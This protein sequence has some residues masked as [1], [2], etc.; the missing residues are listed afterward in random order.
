MSV[1]SDGL[2][3]DGAAALAARLAG[4][5]LPARAVMEAHLNRI[6]A[7][8]P[9]LCAFI[10]VAADEA[11]A[12]AAEL[13]ATL[14]RTGRSAGPL[15]GLPVV[16]KDLTDTAGIRTTYGSALHADH[17]PSTSDIAVARIEAAG[18]IVIGKTNTPEFGF[19]AICR[20]RLAGPTRNPF[21]ARLTSGGSSGGSAVAV[22]AGMAPLAHG[23]DFGGSVRV[24]A[25]F[26]GVASIRP[27]PGLIPSPGR[28]L[29]WD[30][31]A[32][33][34]V[35][36]RDTTDCALL[37]SAMAGS[38]LR[39]P[40]SLFGDRDDGSETRLGATADFGV[41]TVSHAVRE[42]FAAAVEQLERAAGPVARR[43]PDCGDAMATFRTLRAA[44]IRHAYGPL[45][46]SHGD[47][48]TDTVRWNIE[49]GSGITADAYLAAQTARTALYRRFVALFEEID[50]L[51]AP[52]C[53]VLPWPNE[54]GEVTVIDGRPVETILDYLGVTAIVTLIGFPVLTLP[55]GGDGLP[56][57][58]QLIARPGEERR[59]I[60]LG[61]M[62]EREAGFVHRWPPALA[63]R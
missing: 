25:S 38:D 30:T 61:R 63:T 19:G 41:A 11:L 33:H 7:A 28:A 62:L 46:D 15:H 3:Q 6:A 12:R 24:P 18:G 22:A 8:D 4:G 31:L 13:D 43:H 57:G 60:R 21:D 48:L 56:F 52:A 34:G 29:G 40:T 27:T 54:D 59:L 50:V 55:V 37:L 9:D 58:I 51:A 42:R 45:L 47:S 44:Q 2:W 16:V 35:L 36:A 5:E 10:T 49:A 53:G 20:N 26:C 32:T 1:Q 17:V 14:A 23:T 39:D